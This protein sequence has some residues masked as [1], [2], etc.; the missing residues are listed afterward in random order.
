MKKVALAFLAPV[1]MTGG[2]ETATQRPGDEPFRFTSA[3]TPYSAAICIARN[4]RSAS[5]GVRAEERTLGKASWEVV[6]TSRN[7][8]L[9]TVEIHDDGV[10]SAVSVQVTP[11]VR[12]GRQ[13]YAKRLVSGC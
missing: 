12:D 13:D 8:V 6:I 3:R 11:A 9:A 10:G 4:A 7:G 5:G 1:L 2:C